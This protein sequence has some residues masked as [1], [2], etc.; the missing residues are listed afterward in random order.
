MKTYTFYRYDK[1]TYSFTYVKYKNF[2]NFSFLTFFMLTV[3]NLSKLTLISDI[4]I[5]YGTY[6]A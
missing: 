6:Y 3:Y 5:S 2:K 4:K 1:N